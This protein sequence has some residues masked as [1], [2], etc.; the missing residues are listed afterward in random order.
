MSK[1]N[2]WSAAKIKYEVAKKGKTLYAVS[3]DA[4]LDKR[5]CS[6]AIA[7][8]HKKGEAALSD[9]LGV[10]PHIIWPSRYNS[11]GSRLKTQPSTNYNYTKKKSNI[12][13][14]ANNKHSLSEVSH[15]S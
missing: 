12:N 14:K 4:G 3:L 7:Q 15:A 6:N 10:S 1:K 2:D 11:D 13:K 9:F 5:N 8:P